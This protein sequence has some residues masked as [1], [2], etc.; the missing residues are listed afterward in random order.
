MLCLLFCKLY[1][2]DMKF[3]VQFLVLVFNFFYLMGN[4]GRAEV[5]TS[6]TEPDGSGVD[7]LETGKSG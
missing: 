2:Q 7:I 1:F 3:L 4:K 5:R 6:D